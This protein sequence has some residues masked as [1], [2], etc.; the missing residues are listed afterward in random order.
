MFR[1]PKKVRLGLVGIVAMACAVLARGENGSPRWPLLTR[2]VDPKEFGIQDDT[3]TLI[4]ATAFIAVDANSLEVPTVMTTGVNRS[5]QAGIKVEYYAALDIPAGAVIDFIGLDD[6]TDTDGIIGVALY[7]RV[8]DGS[9]NL[10]TAF[11][12]P[13]HPTY[14]Q[15]DGLGPL[16]IPYSGHE[17]EWVINVEQDES[18]TLEWFA[19]VEVHWH[20]TVSLPPPTPTFNDVPNSDPAYQYVEALVASGVTGGCG[21]GNY[22]PDNPVTR[23]QMAVFFA[24]ALGLHY[25]N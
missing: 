20:R 14:F 13:A 24:K 12:V 1:T 18:L 8:A 21:G 11:S 19:W 4:P 16:S 23:R 22:C 5:A 6:A 2:H 9:M 17:S 15:V 3:V 10:I 7:Q 25:P